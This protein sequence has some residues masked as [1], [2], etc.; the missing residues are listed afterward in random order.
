MQTI[1]LTQVPVV[2]NHCHSVM[3]DQTFDD[4]AGWRQ[5]FTESADPGMPRDHVASTA[6]YRRLI[7]TLAAF[8]DC[9]PEEEDVFAAR[10]E[11]EG[12]QLTGAL[13]RA[14]NVEILLIDTGYPPPEE[15]LPGD[16]LAELGRCRVEPMLRLETLME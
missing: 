16:E 8:F 10:A 13:I 1:D 12:S 14:A 15:V 4:I 7:R 5:A 3:Q 11:M 9:E 6:F 2:D